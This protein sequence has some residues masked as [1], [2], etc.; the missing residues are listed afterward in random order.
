MKLIKYKEKF[1]KYGKVKKKYTFLGIPF[2]VRVKQTDKKKL[3]ILGIPVS[4]RVIRGGKKYYYI[5]GIRYSNNSRAAGS[6][7][8]FFKAI[9][10]KPMVLWIDHSLGG[11][12]ETYSMNKFKSLKGTAVVCRLQY[13][14]WDQYYMMSIPN[15]KKSGKYINKDLEQ[16][17]KI[18]KDCNIDKIV[19]NSLVGYDNSLKVLEFVKRLKKHSNKKITV[20]FRGHDFQS[21]CPSFNLLNCDDKFC[22]FKY[23]YG[24]ETCWKNKKLDKNE[25]VDK[26]LRSGAGTITDWRSAWG[27]F[28]TDTCDEIIV[29]SD[30]IAEMFIKS[31]PQLAKKILVI[32]HDFTPLRNVSVAR[33]TGVNIACLGSMQKNK[34]SDI[35]R[36][37][38]NI[39]S[40][41][42]DVQI[43]VIGNMADSPDVPKN[44]IVTGNY[45]LNKLPE[46]IEKN[47]IDLIFIPS[48]CPETF[49]YTTAEA[50]SMGMPVACYDM[51][52]PAERVS[53]YEKGLVL[54]KINPK[55]NLKDIINFANKIKKE[56]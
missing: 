6:A 25:C 12:T 1:Y 45:Q 10:N 30:S 33:H 49:S 50:M 47:K 32:P 4:K 39:L 41:R 54:S 13:Y 34:G 44:L 35:I 15:N 37:M 48:I 52:A 29:F 38:C 42:D 19:I 16:I 9:K 3:R 21:I 46:I 27:R 28:F 7:Y 8:M 11:G 43:F 14:P 56:F 20:S 36:Q 24:C 40:G 31:Y 17:Y 5:F 22:N 2:M 51:G 55:Q 23:R 53:K 26:I 18:L